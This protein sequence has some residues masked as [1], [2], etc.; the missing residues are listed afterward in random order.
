[1]LF[2][3]LVAEI[4]DDPVVRSALNVSMSALNPVT[5]CYHCNINENSTGVDKVN[6]HGADMTLKN[7]TSYM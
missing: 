5:Q 4:K 1:M 6:I 7:W 3:M 2:D